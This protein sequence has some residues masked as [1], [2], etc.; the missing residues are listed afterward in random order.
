VNVLLLQL[1]GQARGCQS[2]FWG[3]FNPW[4]SDTPRPSPPPAAAAGSA[5]QAAGL[6]F[7]AIL[8]LPG[9]VKLGEAGD[10]GRRQ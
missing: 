1:E 8:G 2:K 4:Q 6:E 3:T 10:L 9:A 5:E 7:S